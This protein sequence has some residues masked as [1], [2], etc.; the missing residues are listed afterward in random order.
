MNSLRSAGLIQKVPVPLMVFPLTVVLSGV[1]L[2]HG[3]LMGSCAIRSRRA[4]LRA[5]AV[6]LAAPSRWEPGCS[7]AARGLQ[8]DVVEMV[9]VVLTRSSPL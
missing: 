8:H 7:R 9:G 5:V 6:L 4:L 3:A 1:N 2:S